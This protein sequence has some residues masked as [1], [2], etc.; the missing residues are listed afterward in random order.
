M[1]KLGQVLRDGAFNGMAKCKF[2]PVK[3]KIKL[4]FEQIS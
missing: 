3:N 2:Q 4:I 1:G